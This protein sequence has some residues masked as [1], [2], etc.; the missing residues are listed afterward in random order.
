MTNPARSVLLAMVG[1][2]ALA[3][4]CL[5]ADPGFD[6]ASIKASKLI[7]E[8]AS[9]EKVDTGP[10]RLT[11]TNV[12]LRSIISWAYKVQGA[13]IVGPNWI[14]SERYEILAKTSEPASDDQLRPMLQELLAERFKVTMHRQT[15]ELAAFGLAVA[16]NGIKFRASE[17]DGKSN[18]AMG[19]A[20]VRAERLS[21][22]ELAD[23]LSGPMQATVVDMT[24]LNGVYDLKLD[25]APYFESQQKGEGPAPNIPEI[26]TTALQD[27]LG[28]RL[29]RRKLPVEILVIDRA[30][31]NPTEN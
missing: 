9:R 23:I 16:K 5:A 31:K 20:G 29:D 28:L 11:M 8:G 15:K 6:V 24:E 17:G 3:G 18:I 25:L 2:A 19:K 13:Q 30:E 14:G 12:S 26:V 27:Q 1:L 7:G 22:A 21:M 10:G 4:S